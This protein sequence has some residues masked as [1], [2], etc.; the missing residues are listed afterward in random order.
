MAEALI[1]ILA[2][3]IVVSAL[4]LLP[5]RRL[6]SIDVSL[7]GLRRDLRRTRN[8]V[9]YCH[10]RIDRHDDHAGISTRDP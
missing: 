8:N 4:N 6:K 7:K 1:K 9:G 2:E 5:F 3:L 10:R